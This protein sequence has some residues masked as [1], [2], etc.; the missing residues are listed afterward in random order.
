MSYWQSCVAEPIPGSQ[1]PAFH[2]VQSDVNYEPA[3]EIRIARPPNSVLAYGFTL[4]EQTVRIQP[5][6]RK[7]LPDL[8]RIPIHAPFC[9]SFARLQQSANCR[10]DSSTYGS[11][12]PPFPSLGNRSSQR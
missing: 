2:A 8:A 11:S 5:V 12:G 1:L 10:G 4:R 7:V 6:P 9:I 3:I